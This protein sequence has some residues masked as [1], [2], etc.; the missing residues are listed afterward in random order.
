MTQKATTT[1]PDPE[2]ST[3]LGSGKEVNANAPRQKGDPNQ[4]QQP[5]RP[6]GG[7]APATGEP[8]RDT[9]AATPRRE[10]VV[11]DPDARPRP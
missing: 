3:P 7:G 6:G 4:A 11:S 1:T 8:D 9:D 2:L 10:G 5:Q